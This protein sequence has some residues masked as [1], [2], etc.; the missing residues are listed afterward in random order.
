MSMPGS[1]F[2][3]QR[4]EKLTFSATVELDRH[5]LVHVLVQIK[6]VLLLAL[7]TVFGAGSTTTSAASVTT[8]A[9]STTATTTAA[10]SE[11]AAFRHLYVFFCECFEWYVLLDGDV[12]LSLLFVAASMSHELDRI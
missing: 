7:A 1:P 2:P 12:S 9:T 6:N 4:Q 3:H 11:V 10:G 5:G 8:T